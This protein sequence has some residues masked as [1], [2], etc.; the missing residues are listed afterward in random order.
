MTTLNRT[1]TGQPRLVTLA[2]RPEPIT[3]NADSMDISST[4]VVTAGSGQTVTLQP[5]TNGTL[6]NVGGADVFGTTLG[7][8]D[9]ELDRITAGL[10]QIGNSNSGNINILFAVKKSVGGLYVLKFKISLN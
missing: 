3:V 8:T 6:I 7:L 1:S 10:V 2:A 9:A 4:A 5:E